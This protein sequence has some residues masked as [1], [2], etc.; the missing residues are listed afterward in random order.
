MWR[1]PLQ[2]H[3]CVCVCVFECWCWRVGCV[4]IVSLDVEMA[5]AGAWVCVIECWCWRVFGCV[6]M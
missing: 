5:I 1:W 3:W 6:G 4:G 2:V